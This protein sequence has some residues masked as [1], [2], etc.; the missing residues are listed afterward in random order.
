MKNFLNSRC[1]N[2][3]VIALVT[4][5]AFGGSSYAAPPGPPPTSE[6]TSTGTRSSETADGVNDFGACDEDAHQYCA[7][8]YST[9]WQTS[10]KELG[11]N[12][13]SWKLALVDCLAHH[14]DQLSQDC[15]DSQDRRFVLNQAMV[16]ACAGD[17]GKYC[18]GVEPVP[19]KEPLVDCLK[20]NEDDL[21]A[22]CKAALDAHE[23]AKRS[24]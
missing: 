10:A 2:L 5:V 6:R 17:T 11:Y 14:R 16:M 18:A 1:V 13:D 24:Q 19:G 20:E 12:S 8:L 7:E 22:E 3:S 21:S 9:D 15:K 4:A 23:A